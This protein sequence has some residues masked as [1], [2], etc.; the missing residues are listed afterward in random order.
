[1]GMTLFN[2]ADMQTAVRAGIQYAMNGGRN[3]DTTEQVVLDSWSDRPAD[4]IVDA[5]RYCL[6]D[7]T[8]V[9]CTEW[10]SDGTAPKAYTRITASGTLG[11]FI[12]STPIS[13]DEAARVR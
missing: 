5:T 2:R 12:F 1:M 10:C 6:C 11:F 4:A 13:S 8:S 7:E 3:L 9:A